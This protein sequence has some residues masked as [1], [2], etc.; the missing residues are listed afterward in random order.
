MTTTNLILCGG[1]GHPCEET[2]GPVADLLSE[3]GITSE[4]TD[5]V[6]A[7]MA[8]LRHGGPDLVTVTALRW[9]MRPERYAAQ[10]D[11]WAFE[12]LEP[13]RQG[14]L[15]HVGRGGGVLALHTA[16]ICFD[17]WPEWGRILGGRWDWDAS[18]HP[19]LGAYHIDVSC[20]DDPLVAGL[21]GFD[22][23]DETY[24]ALAL[25]PGVSGVAGVHHDGVDHPLVW[26]HTYGD[27]RVVYDALGHDRRGYE[28]ATQ[29]AIVRRGGRWAATG[30]W[31]P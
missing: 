13:A 27:A 22:T 9:R 11:E 16:S 19:P 10:R 2:A 20:G 4:I 15:A 3:V 8:E 6:G 5:E 30:V 14:M 23:V 12:L 7:A 28:P 24:R 26:R 29:Q 18:Y 25:E 21:D 1:V 17:D 31:G